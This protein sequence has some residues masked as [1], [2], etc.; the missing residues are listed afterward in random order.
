VTLLC[1]EY[2]HSWNG[3]YRRPEGLATGDFSS[4]MKGDLL[5]V[6]EG[7]TQYLGKLLAVR[8]GLRTEADFRD[9]LA[10]LAAYL[11][12][13]PGRTWRPLQ[14]VADEAQLLYGTRGDWSSWRRGV[15][16]YDEGVLVWLEVDVTIRQLTGGKKSLDDFCRA[17]H[18]GGN[19]RPMVKPYSFEDVVAALNSVA[20]YDWDS[21]LTKRLRSLDPHA[22][23][24]G[25]EK[26]G[27][28]VVYGDTPNGLQQSAAG[29]SKTVDLRYSL[30]MTAREDGSII[31][32][33]PNSAAAR[34]GLAPGM[35]IIAVNGRRY[36]KDILN[37]GIVAAKSSSAPLE[38]ITMNNDFIKTYPVDYHGGERYPYLE[39]NSSVPDLLSRVAKPL[40]R[41]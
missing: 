28:N 20:P 24:S 2:V 5:W 40:G 36:T 14:D 29:V 3:K 21:L 1:H 41:N 15:D 9:D 33:L 19:T 16:F 32:V 31:D 34:A 23:L 22:P 37:E 30:G 18:G 11:D 39:R 12:Y 4:P 17:F 38:F 13:R 27:W 8:S 7:L 26:S 35:S 25:L 6:Y 10:G